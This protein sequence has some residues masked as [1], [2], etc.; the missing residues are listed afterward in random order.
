MGLF[1][2]RCGSTA[3]PV[4][5]PSPH[6]V[7]PRNGPNLASL[8]P[9]CT[10]SSLARDLIVYARDGCRKRGA[11]H[12]PRHSS[13][14]IPYVACHRATLSSAC[15]HHY[16]DCQAAR[17]ERQRCPQSSR[18]AVLCIDSSQQRIDWRSA[19]FKTRTAGLSQAR[20]LN[21]T[22]R[23]LYYATDCLFLDVLSRQCR[24]SLN[25]SRQ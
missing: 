3:E 4:T 15:Y 12:Q 17:A 13:S 9:L 6:R 24:P 19:N 5:Y 20:S 18:S 11:R 23:A 21:D 16:L 25:P 2:I 8:P 14:K 1:R 22:H 7:I 10:S